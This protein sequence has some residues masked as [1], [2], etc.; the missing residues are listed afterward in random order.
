MRSGLH[1]PSIFRFWPLN[2]KRPGQ[3]RIRYIEQDSQSADAIFC[4]IKRPLESGRM[5]V[6]QP[7]TP[8][9]LMIENDK[10]VFK[11]F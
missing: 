10:N 3:E 2:H 8:T 4:S 1:P 9:D 5:I 11:Q 6:F 7:P